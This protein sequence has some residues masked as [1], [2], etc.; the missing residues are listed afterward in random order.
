MGRELKRVPLDFDYPLHKV[1]YGYFV[2]NIS[3]CISSQNEE[4]CENCKEFARIKG[5]DTEQYGCPK[6]DE[7]FK[8]IKDKLKELCE[9]PKGE[10]YQLWNT[11]SEGSPI[12]PVFETLDK[13]CEWCEVNATTFGKFKATKKASIHNQVVNKIR[14]EGSYKAKIPYEDVIKT[15]SNL[16]SEVFIEIMETIGLDYAEYEPSFVMIDEVLLK[17]RNEI[18]HGER[19]ESIDL[20]E[21]RFKEIYDVVTDLMNKFVAQITNAVYLKEYKNEYCTTNKIDRK[22]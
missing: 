4:Y 13:L 21:K 1:W 2:D 5:I 7:Y 3:F 20:D 6:F 8:Q 15:G 17:M 16:N 12:S 14:T 22:G 11:T 18:A 19:L 10:G 9:P